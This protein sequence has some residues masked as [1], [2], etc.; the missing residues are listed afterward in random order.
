[1]FL[2]A[3]AIV[4]LGTGAST[5][6]V[7]NQF[8]WKYLVYEVL[9]LWSALSSASGQEL[10]SI[11]AD[12]SAP[13]GK[14]V[15][16]MLGLQQ[17]ILGSALV[18]LK[19]YQAAVHAYRQCIAQRSEVSYAAAAAAAGSSTGDDFHHVCAYAHYELAM[20]LLQCSTDVSI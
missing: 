17:L 13:L 9:F 2:A 19:Q 1:M 11:V 10:S 5:M 4:L 20:L 14:Y 7:Y 6:A 12:C 15:E 8:Y 3:A 16:P 18:S